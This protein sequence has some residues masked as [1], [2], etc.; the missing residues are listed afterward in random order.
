MNISLNLVSCFSELLYGGCVYAVSG[1][2]DNDIIIIVV[3]FELY[4]PLLCTLFFLL[5]FYMFVCPLGPIKKVT[6][7]GLLLYDVL[8]W[9]CIYNECL[10]S[11]VFPVF[12]IIAYV[13]AWY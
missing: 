6:A 12:W 10:I 11:S 7:I 8:L 4:R 5:N 1:V 2:T 9:T 13:I 3:F